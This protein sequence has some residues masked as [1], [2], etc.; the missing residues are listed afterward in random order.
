M[1]F[2]TFFFANSIMLNMITATFWRFKYLPCEDNVQ[3]QYVYQLMYMKMIN[4]DTTLL[5]NYFRWCKL[6]VTLLTWL[7]ATRFL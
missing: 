3:Y 6:V 1:L 5:T 7:P 2:T 4:G